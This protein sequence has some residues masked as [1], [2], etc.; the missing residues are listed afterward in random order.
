MHAVLSVQSG[1]FWTCHPDQCR[2]HSRECRALKI[3]VEAHPRHRRAATG[4]YNRSYQIFSLYSND[5]DRAQTGTLHIPAAWLGHRIVMDVRPIPGIFLRQC[6]SKLK[7]SVRRC[8]STP[9]TNV[10]GCRRH[11]TERRIDLPHESRRFEALCKR[12]QSYCRWLVEVRVGKTHRR[13]SR[14]ICSSLWIRNCRMTRCSKSW[15][16]KGD[17]GI[18]SSIAACAGNVMTWML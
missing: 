3:H 5:P 8:S 9:A 14:T 10:S 2:G 12:V 15:S 7:A 17:Q 1:E 4:G 16:R 18:Q 6:C 13:G 11:A